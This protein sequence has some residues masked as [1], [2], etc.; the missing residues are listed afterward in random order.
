MAKIQ[1]IVGTVNG[2][3]WQVGEVVAALLRKL[4]HDVETNEESV[5]ADLL[6][7]PE[8]ILLVCCATT[9]DGEVPRNIYPVYAAL[10]NEAVSLKG[11]Q[12]GVISLGD[13]GYPRFAHAGLLLE[14]AFYRSGATRLGEVF[15]LDAQQHDKP[16]LEAA[17]W[18]KDWI[19]AVA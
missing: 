3:A 15:T 9:G 19:T 10:D 12:Y 5:P 1:L 6:R 8:E 2:T 16:A 4:G 18:A 11:R 7:D 13:S 14:D 17:M